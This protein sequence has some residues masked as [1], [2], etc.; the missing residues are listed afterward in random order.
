MGLL[1]DK[2]KQ[3]LMQNIFTSNLKTFETIDSKFKLNNEDKSKVL[4]LVSKF[5]E[6]LNKLLKNAKLS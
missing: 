6:E 5:N 4:D 3:D 2:I 1:E